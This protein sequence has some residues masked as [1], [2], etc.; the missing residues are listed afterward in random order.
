L[1]IVNRSFVEA[2]H[3]AEIQ[4]HVWTIDDENEMIRLLDLGVDGI[5]TDRPESLKKVLLSR[6]AWRGN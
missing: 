5:M 6:N 4:V 2:A 3:N 1:T